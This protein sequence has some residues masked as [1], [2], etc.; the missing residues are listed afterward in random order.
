MILSGLSCAYRYGIDTDTAANGLKAL[1]SRRTDF[2]FD[3][4]PRRKPLEMS[5]DRVVPPTTCVRLPAVSYF[6][7]TRRHANGV[8][9]ITVQNVNDPRLQI[10]TRD[11]RETIT[12]C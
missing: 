11:E 3:F 8:I 1:V 4:F 12:A 2:S 9:A 7:T 10:N 5:S 6:N